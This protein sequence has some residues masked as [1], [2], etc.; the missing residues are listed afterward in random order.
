M[1]T[2]KRSRMEW[3]DWPREQLLDMRIRDLGL[4]LEGTWLEVRVR[5]LYHELAQRGIA[6]R[7]HCWL[8][9]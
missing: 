2:R 8:S 3:E 5:A 9:D 6:L 1:S 4:R 7:P